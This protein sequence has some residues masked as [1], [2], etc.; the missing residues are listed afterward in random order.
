MYGRSKLV[1]VLLGSSCLMEI[2]QGFAPNQMDQTTNPDY[3]RDGVN[4]M[5]G[6]D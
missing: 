3:S 1:W 4:R 2:L 5:V 6:V